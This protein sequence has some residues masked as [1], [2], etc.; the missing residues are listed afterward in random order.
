MAGDFHGECDV[1][2]RYDPVEEPPSQV[3]PR[4]VACATGRETLA[5]DPL[6]HSVQPDALDALVRRSD[7]LVRLSFRYAD[8]RVRI[9]DE[10]VSV[11][12]RRGAD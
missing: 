2:Y 7:S 10:R 1:A 4:A 9:D 3:V 12:L 5:L 8:C 6:Y 11:W